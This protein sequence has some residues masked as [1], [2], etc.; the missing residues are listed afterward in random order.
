M[1]T[2][3]LA[4]ACGVGADRSVA[5]GAAARR[6]AD[7]PQAGRATDPEVAAV[8]QRRRF[9]DQYKLKLLEEIDGSPEMTG[10]IIRREGLYSSNISTW[11]RWRERMGTEKKPISENKRLHNEMAKLK[12]EN[13]RLAMKLRQAEA[14]IDLQKKTSEILELMSQNRNDESS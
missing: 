2:L 1:S 14:L 12:R 6:A 4:P 10:M 3:A 7:S 11:R 5:A 8:G 13:E 9:S